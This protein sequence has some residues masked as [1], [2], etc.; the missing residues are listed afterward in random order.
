MKNIDEFLKKNWFIGLVYKFILILFVLSMGALLWRFQM[1]PPLVPLWYSR[2]WGTD[3]L[4]SPY[5]LLVLPL[6]SIL[7]FGIDVLVGMYITAEYLIFT[8]MLFLSS[9]IVS[10][11]SFVTLIKILFIVT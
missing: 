8:Q 5:W 10:V 4:A 7:L 3:Q 11:L 1:L 2:P 9:L 6:T